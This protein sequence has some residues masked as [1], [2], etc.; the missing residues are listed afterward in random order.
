[1]TRLATQPRNVPVTQRVHRVDGATS[2][3]PGFA[4]PIAAIPLLRGDSAAGTIRITTEMRETREIL[5]NGVHARFYAVF[6]P[7]AADPR[8]N[9]SMDQL[10][11][12]FLGKPP[13]EGAPVVPYFATFTAPAS[14]SEHPILA[15]LGM[16]FKGGTTL[17]NGHTIAYNLAQN[18]RRKQRSLQLPMRLVTDTSLDAAM[19]P[20]DGRFANLV[21]DFDLS[22]M[23]GEVPVNIINSLLPVR[24]LGVNAAAGSPPATATNANFRE[25]GKTVPRPVTHNSNAGN[26]A[27]VEMAD[28]WPKVFAE[29]QDNG[30]SMTLTGLAQAPKLQSFAAVRRM[31]EGH[32]DDDIIDML[33][34]GLEISDLNLTQ[35]WV[36]GQSTKGFIKQMK[37]FSTTAQ[38]LDD[39]ATNG[40][41]VSH[42]NIR[43]PRQKCGGLIMIMAEY[44]P[45][46]LYERQADVYLHT[47]SADELPNAYV[48]ELGEIRVDH[49]LN[50]EI[51]VTH[52]E[53]DGLFAYGPKWW[54]YAANGFR[55]GG[56]FLQLVAGTNAK[57]RQRFWA[58]EQRNPKLAEDFYMSIRGVHKKVF[59]DE[60]AHPFEIATEGALTISGL[61]Q[62]GAK[63]IEE[64]GNFDAVKVMVPD[65]F[66]KVE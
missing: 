52:N 42:L 62:F 56:K 66:E 12:S 35:P 32:S 51:D 44:L 13:Y 3:D 47:V 53:P 22:A 36:C 26:P 5:M 59:L 65:Q 25:T 49:V 14:V 10:N 38:Q 63:L 7:H 4:I 60:T 50:K 64:T 46:Q 28:G 20:D 16:H 39:S 21:P 48:D 29:M 45:Q 61:T 24:G 1:M 33:M 57:E 23:F 43:V 18:Y 19:W 11:A 41:N 2:G 40:L 58:V 15:A 8:F 27:V 34:A 54:K 17:N 37:R 6:V 31:Y 9:G 30:L 55:I